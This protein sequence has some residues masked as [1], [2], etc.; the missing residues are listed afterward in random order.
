M[1]AQNAW[2]LSCPAPKSGR[3]VE[4]YYNAG[5][6]IADDRNGP[7]PEDTKVQIVAEVSLQDYEN[8]INSLKAEGGNVYLENQ[9]A[10]DLFFAYEHSGKNY[11]VRFCAKRG[12]IRVAEEP[13]YV[14]PTGFGYK[15]A[16]PEQSILYQ[17]GLYYDPDNNVTPTTV[18]CGMLYIIRL[19]DNSLFMMDGGHYRQWPKAAIDGLWQFLRQITNT[20]EDGIVRISAWY[21]THTHAD[22]IDG[23]PKLLRKYH[24]NIVIERLLYNF[25][26]YDALG[27]YEPSIFHVKE[28]MSKWYPDVKFLKLHAGQ[29]FDLADMNV[30]VF[31]AQE[32][33]ISEGNMAR[34]PLRD[35]NCMSTILKLTIGGKTAMMLGD[36]NIEAEAWIAGNSAPGPWK[37]DLVQLAHH[38]FN[39]L[40]TLYAWIEAPV[41]L[42]PNS[43]G[44]AHQPE[45]T[46]KLIGAEKFV[47]DGQIWYEGGGTDG[48]IATEVGWKHVAHYPVVGSEYDGTGY[49]D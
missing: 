2:V 36:T 46:P 10:D 28:Q 13:N 4:G 33:A 43:Y 45:N 17:Y 19:S 39:Y 12:E 41:V 38:C 21:F 3:I 44:G 24:D 37:S 23:C 20:P 34:F 27:G 9:I 48:F 42:V 8:Y 40:D 32:D 18:N 16:G 25:P 11:H 26:H 6:I 5:P 14:S 22:H 15:A 30:E 29:K 35:G 31:Y 7:T 49:W 1:N 47:K